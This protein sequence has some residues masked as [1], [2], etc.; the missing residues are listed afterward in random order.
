VFAG[1]EPKEAILAAT[2]T[3]AAL[4]RERGLGVIEAGACADLVLLDPDLEAVATIVGG[5]VAFE[6]RS[7][8]G[9]VDGR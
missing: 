1:A 8:S 3:P 2:Q 5:E 4:L 7:A 6:R 9:S